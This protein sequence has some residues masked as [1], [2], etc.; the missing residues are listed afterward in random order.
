[1]ALIH[2]PFDII[3][4]ILFCSQLTSHLVDA[5]GNVPQR[6]S[7]VCG[8]VLQDWPNRILSHSVE[9]CQDNY[10]FNYWLECGLDSLTD[11][12]DKVLFTLVFLLKF[13]TM[14]HTAQFSCANSKESTRSSQ[15]CCHLKHIFWHCNQTSGEMES[16]LQQL[17]DILP[18]AF[19]DIG[20]TEQYRPGLQVH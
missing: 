20:H 6:T 17:Y 8:Y 1:M 9:S 11:E 14:Q 18:I 15:Y 12:W 4:V 5:M 19:K 16:Y 10:S 7:F 13:L 3:F 2:L